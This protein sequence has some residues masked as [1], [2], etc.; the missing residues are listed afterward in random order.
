MRTF[1]F[2]VALVSLVLVAVPVSAQGAPEPAPVPEPAAAAVAAGDETSAKVVAFFEA[3]ATIADDNKTK[4]GE[5][6]IALNN[7]LNEN[8]KLLRDSAYSDSAA[9]PTEELAIMNAATQ[10]GEHAGVCYEE[11]TVITFFERFI[12]LTTELDAG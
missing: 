10:L 7:A 6:G 11:A 5:M 8:E 2:V 12:K 4:C 9:S 3:L 1:T